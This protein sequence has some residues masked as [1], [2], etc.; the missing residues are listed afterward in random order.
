MVATD[1]LPETQVPP[2]VDEDREVD[3]PAHKFIIPDILVGPGL[4]AIIAVA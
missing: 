2:V 4:T 1:V 3:E